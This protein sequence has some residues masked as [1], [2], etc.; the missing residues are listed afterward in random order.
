MAHFAVS[1]RQ[2]ENC[3]FAVVVDDDG[4]APRGRPADA[5]LMEAARTGPGLKTME[6]FV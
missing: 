1:P 4:M 5:G 3:E 2:H 6:G